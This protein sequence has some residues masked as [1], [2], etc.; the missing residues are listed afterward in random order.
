MFDLISEAYE[1]SA[2][3]GKTPVRK[4]LARAAREARSIIDAR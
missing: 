3:Y 2:I 1:E 4:A